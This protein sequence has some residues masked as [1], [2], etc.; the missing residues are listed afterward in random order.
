MIQ[1]HYNVN[2]FALYY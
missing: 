2:T 1:T